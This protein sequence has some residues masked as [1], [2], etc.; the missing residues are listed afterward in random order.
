MYDS[1]VLSA[2]EPEYGPQAIKRQPRFDDEGER[3]Y[4]IAAQHGTDRLP[5]SRSRRQ[6]A[7]GGWK[8][9]LARAMGDNASADCR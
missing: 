1:G 7:R 9:E 2:G 4:G 3:R 8:M 6:A 5:K